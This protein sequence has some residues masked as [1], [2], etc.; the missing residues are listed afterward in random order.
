LS[1]VNGNSGQ[2][3]PP[4]MYPLYIGLS[5]PQ[6][7]WTATAATDIL[8]VGICILIL[9]CWDIVS[10]LFEGTRW[11]HFLCVTTIMSYSCNEYDMI[12]RSCM[13][14]TSYNLCRYAETKLLVTRIWIRFYSNCSSIYFVNVC[15]SFV[16]D[17][18]TVTESADIQK[19]V[20]TVLYL[21]SIVKIDWVY[22]DMDIKH[23]IWDIFE[24]PFLGSLKRS[25]EHSTSCY[26]RGVAEAG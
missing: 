15:G 21:N 13:L 24:R 18:D 10:V 20:I 19:V 8:F 1:V 6:H 23:K 11:T 16:F 26:S 7:W 3:C 17:N 4:S 5:I 12:V 25:R 9:I 2:V 14:N 22:N